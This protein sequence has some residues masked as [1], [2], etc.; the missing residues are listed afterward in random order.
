MIVINRSG[1][2]GLSFNCT[3]FWNGLYFSAGDMGQ[4]LGSSESQ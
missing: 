3:L 2:G 4:F 1:L